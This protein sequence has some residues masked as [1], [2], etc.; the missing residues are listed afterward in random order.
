MLRILVASDLSPAA[1]RAMRRAGAL[2]ITSAASL[3]T[4]HVAGPGTP[5]SDRAALAERLHAQRHS[6]APPDLA[7]AGIAVLTGDPPATI[8]REAERH[9]ADLIVLGA[10]GKMLLRDAWLGTT[11]TQVIRRSAIPVLVVR[12]D[13]QGPYRRVLAAIDDTTVARKVIQLAN[14]VAGAT[15][16]FAV[17]AFHIPFG[18][19]V[20]GVQVREDV[21]ADHRHVIESLIADLAPSAGALRLHSYIKEGEPLGVISQAASEIEPDLLILGTH[22]RRD[23]AGALIDSVAEGALQR[24]DIDI[25]VQ[26]TGGGASLTTL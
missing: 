10:H 13:T 18:A 1:A 7:D 4:V 8:L 17:H 2:A 22:G 26:R 14:R 15:D 3:R 25:I 19:F 23:L 5:E 6:L 16:L 9:E 20:D 12:R 21:E 11:A 24:F